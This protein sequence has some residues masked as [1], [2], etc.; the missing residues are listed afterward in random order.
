MGNVWRKPENIKIK[1]TRSNIGAGIRINSPI[2]LL[3]FD[4]GI[5]FAPKTGEPTAVPYFSMG[6]AF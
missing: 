6:H 4:Y 3:R 5:N 2:G 1:D